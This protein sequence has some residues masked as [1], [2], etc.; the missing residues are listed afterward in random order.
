MTAGEE[1]PED[2]P[3]PKNQDKGLKRAIYSF[4]NFFF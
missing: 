2:V 3:C 1:F 4:F